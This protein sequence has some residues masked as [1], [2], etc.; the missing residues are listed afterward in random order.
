[1][2]NPETLQ[3]KLIGSSMA[4]LDNGNY[5]EK[6][7]KMLDK[8]LSLLFRALY[9]FV[10]LVSAAATLYFA[11][12]VFKKHFGNEFSAFIMRV[13]CGAGM[14]FS[15]ILMLFAGWSAITAKVKGR[16]YPGFIFSSIIVVLCYFSVALFYMMYILPV[17]MELSNSSETPFFYTSTMVIQLMLFGFFAMVA[18]GLIFLFRLLSDLKFKSQQ[19]LLEI[20][21]KLC[22][23]MEKIEKK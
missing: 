7:Q 6:I 17:M 15:G 18:V 5:R 19:K 16:F 4:D 21:D 22:E 20:E 3:D 2:K 12:W 14:I 1:M 10:C 8:K 23:L 11:S 9:G 13:I